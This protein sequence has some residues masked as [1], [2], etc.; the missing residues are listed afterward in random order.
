MTI[1]NPC[2]KKLEAPWL[3]KPEAEVEMAK[4]A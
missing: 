1:N 4:A 3:K 2:W